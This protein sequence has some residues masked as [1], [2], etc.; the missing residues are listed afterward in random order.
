MKAIIVGGGKLGFK[1]AEA[2]VKEEVEV[3]VID[4]DPRVINMVNE[5]LDVLTVLSNGIDINVYKELG[6]S[7]YD[8]LVAS[9]NSDETNTLICSLTKKLNCKKTIARIRNPE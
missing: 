5:H 2:F 7:H 9:T 4:H 1:L 8:L 6:I 3:T